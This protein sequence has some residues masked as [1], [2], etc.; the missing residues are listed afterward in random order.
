MTEKQYLKRLGER[1]RRLRKESG[2][3]MEQLADKANLTRM[4]VYRIEKARSEPSLIVLRRIAKILRV[5]LRDLI[6]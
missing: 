2:L 6:E 3:T 4:H 5:K 1:V